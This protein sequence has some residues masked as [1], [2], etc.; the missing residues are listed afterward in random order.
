M[1]GVEAEQRNAALQSQVRLHPSCGLTAP[2]LLK[3]LHTE[4]NHTFCGASELALPPN[5]TRVF[6][7]DS[8]SSACDKKTIVRDLCPESEELFVSD[9]HPESRAAKAK[10]PANATSLIG[11]TGREARMHF[12]SQIYTEIWPTKNATHAGHKPRYTGRLYHT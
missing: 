2:A 3:K 8:M 11:G 10:N 1:Q 7:D 4:H 12:L 5:T 9:L 6:A